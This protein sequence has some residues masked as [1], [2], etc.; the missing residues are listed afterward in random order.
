MR[1]PM[2][3][4]CHRVRV[5]VY[6]YHEGLPRYLL[7]RGAQLESFWTPIHGP[8]AFGEKL[9]SAIRREVMDDIGLT[10]PNRLIDLEMPTR[11]Q[12]GDEETI[13]W[14][15]GF[16]AQPRGGDLRVDPRR[17]ADFRWVQFPEAYPSLELECDRA[18]I[19]R[20]HAMLHAS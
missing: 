18:A 12:L 2:R 17:W 10:R 16:H 7:L 6:R 4:L 9:E 14:V 11:W 1:D 13:E 3:E 20:L 15:F 8:I 5:F 19:M